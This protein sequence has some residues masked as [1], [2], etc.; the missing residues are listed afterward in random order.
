MDAMQNPSDPAEQIDRNSGPIELQDDLEGDA[1]REESRILHAGHIV[2][3]SMN[4]EKRR[5]DFIE[6]AFHGL[7]EAERLANRDA[8]KLGV[9]VFLRHLRRIARIH[10]GDDVADALVLDSVRRGLVIRHDVAQRR[11]RQQRQKVALLEARHVPAVIEERRRERGHAVDV[12]GMI[13]RELQRE[14]GAH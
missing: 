11:V 2:L 1:L 4:D 6:D 13:G 8:R 14:Q 9:A 3:G 7:D 12:V 10:R 5:G